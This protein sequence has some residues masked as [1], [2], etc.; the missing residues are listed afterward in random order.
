MKRDLSEICNDI[1]KASSQEEL[2]L[3]KNE[4]MTMG[5]FDLLNYVYFIENLKGLESL[6]DSIALEKRGE[7]EK[8]ISDYQKMV[9]KLTLIQEK[10]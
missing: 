8:A 7:L 4:A 9:L 6:R 1:N 2:D 10:K 3:L 5:H